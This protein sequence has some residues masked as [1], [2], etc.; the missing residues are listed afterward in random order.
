MS[1]YSITAVEYAK[2]EHFNNTMIYGGYYGTGEVRIT[3]TVDVLKSDNELIVVDTG[4]DMNEIEAIQHAT[5]ESHTDYKSP[6]EVLERAGV[7]PKDVKHVI[8]THAHWDHMGGLH[9]FPNAKFYLQKDELLNWIKI[10]AMSREY[11]TLKNPMAY[12][13]VEEA[14]ALMKEGRLVLLDGDVSQLFP[15]IDIK[16]A[17]FGHSFA[18]NVIYVNTKAGTYVITGDTAYV[19]ENITGVNDSGI[20]LPN[21]YAIGS[22]INTITTM[23]DTLK[24]VN[25]DITKIIIGH[26]DKMW[27]EYKSVLHDDNLHVAYIVE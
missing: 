16:V 19:K 8:L 15:G 6:A 25:G 14:V 20:S 24:N 11:D 3:Y 18:Q 13:N 4:Y 27:D 26:D 17:R 12:A 7:N 9:F 1:I 21:G 23:Q 10:L 5:A 2:V 22:I